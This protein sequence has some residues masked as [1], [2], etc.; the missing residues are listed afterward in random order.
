MATN[1]W[2]EPFETWTDKKSG[3][4]WMLNNQ[5]RGDFS[6]ARDDIEEVPG[7]RLPSIDDF[8]TLLGE[9]KAGT[10]DNETKDEDDNYIMTETPMFDFSQTYWA[11]DGEI[12][13]LKR[14]AVSFER[15]VWRRDNY[16]RMR[17]YV[18]SRN[19][20]KMYLMVKG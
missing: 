6:L 7:W 16:W 2:I 4:I 15:V 17:F 14:T 11:S 13:D 1:W 10:A 18:S 20:P 3:L 19:N 5:R 12:G 9:W 8:K